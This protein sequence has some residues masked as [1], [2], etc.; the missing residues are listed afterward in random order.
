MGFLDS[1]MKG[2]EEKNETSSSS[3]VPFKVNVNFSPLRLTA[4]RDNK[5]NLIVRIA[6]VSGDDQLVS[7]DASL[8]RNQLVGFEPTCIHKMIE[9]KVGQLK[10][11]ETTEIVLPIWANNQTKDGN[12]PIEVTVYAHYLDYS[13]VIN[14]VRK[15]IS[16]RVV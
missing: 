6:N 3:G 14:S 9:K 8:P 13:K 4:M 11:N 2:E 12:Y 15:N 16:L 7:V 10:A 1:L 5:V